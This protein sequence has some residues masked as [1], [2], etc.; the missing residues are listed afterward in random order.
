M[1]VN[2]YEC[3]I[4][5]DPTKASG[6]AENARNQIHAILEK[7][8]CEILESR[9]W[10][11]KRLAYP[12]GHHKKGVYYIVYF[13]TDSANI[14]EIESDF[15]INELILRYLTQKLH[16]KWVDRLLEATRAE[17][18]G[19][20]RIAGDEGEGGEPVGA[21]AGRPERGGRGERAERGERGG[22]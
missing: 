7:H 17:R 4:L 11:E 20:V 15:R 13:R 19:A 18:A 12:I 16:P 9:V 14:K 22:E 10:D 2:T 8:H 5:L 3:L 1:P 21:G 6:E